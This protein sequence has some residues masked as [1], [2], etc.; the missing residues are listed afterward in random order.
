MA[1]KVWNMAYKVLDFPKCG[2]FSSSFHPR[3]NAGPSGSRIACGS[4]NDGFR[5]GFSFLRCSTDEKCW[6]SFYRFWPFSKF[7]LEAPTRAV[8]RYSLFLP[9]ESCSQLQMLVTGTL[10]GAFGAPVSKNLNFSFFQIST[11]L[12]S[13]FSSTHKGCRY[14]ILGFK[15][16]LS[17]PNNGYRHTFRSLGHIIVEKF[18]F[19]IFSDFDHLP[20]RML[21][22]SLV[23]ESYPKFWYRFLSSTIKQLNTSGSFFSDIEHFPI[24]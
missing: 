23:Q 13:F 20:L 22:P 5:H 6:F 24:F 17:T 2:R 8:C 11:I 18:G 12:D 10:L 21:L 16:V 1:G 4:P 3:T 14:G 9:A 15:I 7:F 19:S